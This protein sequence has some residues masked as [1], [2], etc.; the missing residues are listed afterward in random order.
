MPTESKVH[1]IILNIWDL[2]KTTVSDW[3]ELK[4]FRQSAIIAYYAIF[5]LPALLV[6]I[7]TIAGTLY[8]PVTITEE[9]YEEISSTMGQKTA[10]E[11]LG[12][13]A[14]ANKVK[15][16]LWGT[17]LGIV[18][19]LVGA[20]G[21]FVQVQKTLNM[22]WKVEAVQRKGI[23]TMLRMRLFSFGLILT[24][25]F[26]LIVSLTVSTLLAAASDLFKTENV[27]NLLPLIRILNFAVSLAVISLLFSLMFRYLPDARVKWRYVWLGGLITSL[28]FT[29]GK[30]VLAF[31]FAKAAPGSVYGAAGSVILIL[32]WTSYSSMILF[33][34][35]VFTHTYANKYS[36]GEEVTDNKEELAA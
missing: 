11:V 34:G 27:T 4:P 28:L 12:I 21:A 6:I 18:M 19:I 33:F 10:D 16:T 26:L 13:M 8:D 7:I 3:W 31:Y 15:T 2:I 9:I 35:A 30:A 29:L 32:L 24:L 22:I 36:R 1:S 5:S 20:V 14:N 17:I 23:W 25:T